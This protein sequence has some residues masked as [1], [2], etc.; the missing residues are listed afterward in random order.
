MNKIKKY[1]GICAAVCLALSGCGARPD[2]AEAENVSAQEAEDGPEQEMESTSTLEAENVSTQETEDGPE[3]ETESGSE[4]EAE[5]VSGQEDGPA[6]QERP[7]KQATEPVTL[8]SAYDGRKEGRAPSVKNQGSLGKCWAF[9]S[10]TALEASLLPEEKLDFSED[11]MSLNQNFLLGQNDGGDYTMSMA[12]LLSWQ[13]PVLEQDDPYGDKVSPSGLSAVKHVQEIRILKPKD[14]DAIKQA[15]LEYGGVQ[16]SLYTSM[17]NSQSQS[18]DYDPDHGSYYY[19]GKE[20][21]NHDSVIIGWDDDFPKEYFRIPPPDDG[22]FL[23]M[24]SWGE[25]FGDGGCFYV[26]YYDTNIGL[27]NI[28]YTGIEEPDN[29][30]R[31][32]QTDLCGWVGQ[33]GYGTDGPLGNAWFAN[34]YEAQGKETLKAV[35]FYATGPDTSYEIYVAKG[36][37]LTEREKAAAGSLKD[38]GY[39][40]IPL[41]NQFAL[42]PG[43]RFGVIVK[44]YTPG[45]DHPVAIEYDAQDGKCR[46]DLTDGEGYISLQ[47]EI[48]ERVE[49]KQECNICLKAY[50]EEIKS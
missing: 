17:K 30:S 33:M 40:T 21:P 11:H 5:N 41:E 16:S 48:W 7:E 14:Y 35:G 2:G 27:H 29:Y 10:L 12:Y 13:G 18:Q 32:Y 43:E 38:A 50:T 46:I 49:E 22:A 25:A 34:I 31:I 28:V 19:D 9:A 20:S 47:G 3:Q 42:E 44:I 37:K 39:Y 26:S 6:Q 1:I 8:L 4:Q 24:N 15:V 23:C 45:K 36:G